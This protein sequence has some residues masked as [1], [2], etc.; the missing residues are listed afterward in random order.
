MPMLRSWRR[1]FGEF[2]ASHRQQYER[3]QKERDEW[4]EIPLSRR[5]LPA[6]PKPP[7][8]LHVDREGTPWIV[9]E[10]FLAALDNLIEGLAEETG[11]E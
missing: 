4:W 6:P 5:S 9:N 11:P 1:E 10:R 7:R 8:A 3:M 2:L